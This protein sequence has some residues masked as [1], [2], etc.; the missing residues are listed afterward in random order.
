MTSQETVCGD[1]SLIG[2]MIWA[3]QD[4]IE[5]MSLMNATHE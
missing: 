4:K 3:T 5:V 2:Q 1:V